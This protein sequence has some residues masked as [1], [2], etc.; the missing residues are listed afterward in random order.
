MQTDIFSHPWSGVF[1]ATLC[2]FHEDESI[3]EPGLRAYFR[4]LAGVDGVKGLVCNGHTG[5]IMSLRP[6]ERARVTRIAA[7]ILCAACIFS[8]SWTIAA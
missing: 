3:N 5:E 4:E 6:P 8:R 7:D 2:P 1:P